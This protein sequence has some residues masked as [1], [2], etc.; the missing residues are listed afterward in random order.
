MSETTDRY[1]ALKSNCS[2]LL[3]ILGQKSVKTAKIASKDPRIAAWVIFLTTTMQEDKVDLN[4]QLTESVYSTQARPCQIQHLQP[5]LK[6]NPF[7][8]KYLI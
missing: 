5:K 8:T 3:C 2:R 1:I 4:R 6:I 7:R